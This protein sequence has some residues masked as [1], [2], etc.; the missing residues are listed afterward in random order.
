LTNSLKVLGVTEKAHA[1]LL[2]SNKLQT[3][4]KSKIS[5]VKDRV[6]VLQQK[7]DAKEKQLNRTDNTIG[8]SIIQEMKKHS[9]I[10]K[11][12]EQYERDFIKIQEEFE[13]KKTQLYDNFNPELEL[14]N[15]EIT[16][17]KKE[18]KS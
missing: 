15:H 7:L 13:S 4:I 8:S 6:K 11:R 16:K 1:S 10:K 9:L 3:T 2:N 12:L 5:E 17:L 18:N 14:M